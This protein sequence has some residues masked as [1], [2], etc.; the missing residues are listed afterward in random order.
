MN[1][2]EEYLER[3]Q[4]LSHDTKIKIMWIGVPVVMAIVIFIWLPYA[5]F[6]SKESV[7]ADAA[8]DNEISKFE[9]LKNGFNV[10]FKEIG[11]LFGD[12]KE[13]IGQTNSFE[14]QA[15]QQNDGS[16]ATTTVQ[17]DGVKTAAVAT[18]TQSEGISENKSATTTKQ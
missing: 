13:K 5:D 15:P 10:T 2:L 7:I 4:N 18:T 9:I 12:L 14:I 3:L 11:D 1:E 8:G 17:V 6:G 16:V